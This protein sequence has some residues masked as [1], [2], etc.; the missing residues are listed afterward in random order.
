MDLRP[1]LDEIVN[2]IFGQHVE[3]GVERLA[4]CGVQAAA[5][6]Q[7]TIGRAVVERFLDSGAAVAIWDRDL[8]L[9][10]KTAAALQRHGRVIAV[11]ADV[12]AYTDV[13]R[14]HAETLQAFG[15][16]DIL[17]NN[18]GISGPNTPTWDYPLEAWRQVMAINLDGPFHC[19]RALAPGM[20]AQ[21]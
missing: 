10:Q 7:R 11:A 6:D 21:N 5:V 2:R 14:A 9:A 20:I 18:A 13:E 3:E 8:D 12:T 15:R 16:I 17:V 4:Q 1:G 19:A